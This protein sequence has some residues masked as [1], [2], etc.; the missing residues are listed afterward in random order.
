MK[1]KI[2]PKN[3]L[4]K[5]QLEYIEERLSIPKHQ[6]DG[7]PPNVWSI[8][9]QGLFAFLDTESSIPIGLVEASGPNDQIAPSWWLDIRYRG[10]GYGNE[11][12]DT[13][14]CYLKK[15]GVTGVGKIQIKTHQGSY[16]ETSISLAKRF[17]KHFE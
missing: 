12:V 9:K 2:V 5:E 14:A 1:L 4:T 3:E 13:L 11:V 8:Y 7:G 15:Q 6:F 16:D 17:K 10:K